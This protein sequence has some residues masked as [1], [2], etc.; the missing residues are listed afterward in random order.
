MEP[1]EFIS[2]GFPLSDNWYH[3][4]IMAFT[5]RVHPFR[6]NKNLI[7]GSFP[8]FRR[9]GP[10]Q[11]VYHALPASNTNQWK[12]LM[13]TLWHSHQST[14]EFLAIFV[15]IYGTPPENERMSPEKGPFQKENRLPASIFQGIWMLVFGEVTSDSSP[16]SLP[17][18][19]FVQR[20]HAFSQRWIDCVDTSWDPITCEW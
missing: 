4:D 17:T 11:S 12:L 10:Y 14:W 7:R 1:C 18:P 6:F 13:F 19:F 16:S 15:Y 8:A 9:F 20:F 3:G 5:L 2:E